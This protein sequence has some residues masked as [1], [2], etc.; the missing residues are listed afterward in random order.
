MNKLIVIVG[1]GRQGRVIFDVFD[2]DEAGSL[3]AGYLD[4]TKPVGELIRGFPVLNGFAAIHDRTFVLDHAWIVAIGDN[5]I[6]RDLY[7]VLAE[8]GA[9]IVN[10][11]DPTA[12]ISRAATLGRGIYIGPLTSVGPGTAISDWA[13]IEGHGRIGADVRIGEAA[14]FGPGVIATGGASIGACSFLGAGTIIANN[15]RVGADCVVGANSAVV[16]DLPD[17]ISA[18]GSPARPAPLRRRPFKR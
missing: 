12:Q 17:G 5:L 15:V 16:R 2:K 4:D 13:T 18:Y 3:V 10:A 8:A 7:R 11:V 1:A 6:R 9:T 14:F